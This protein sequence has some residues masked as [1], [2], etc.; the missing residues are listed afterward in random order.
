[1][2]KNWK[3]FAKIFPPKIKTFL[4]IYSQGTCAGEKCDEQNMYI[5]N[6]NP[7]ILTK[8][9]SISYRILPSVWLAVTV[10]L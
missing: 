7:L 1:M 10:L 2:S 6:T 3:S 8:G 4:C 9:S 5:M